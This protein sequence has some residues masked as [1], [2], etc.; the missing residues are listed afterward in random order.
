MPRRSLF[1]L[2]CVIALQRAAFAQDSA[3]V[4]WIRET[5]IPLR[6]VDAG[7]GFAD[8]APLKAVLANVRI[9]GLGESSHGTSEFQRVKHRLF[10]FLV[11]EMGYTVF[12][13]E[14]SYSDAQ[15]MNDYILH[16][17]GN[18]ADVLS[19]LGYVAWDME[20]F[21]AMV[22]W[23]RA[24]NRTVPEARK[25]RF[26]G[27][28]I[29]R[30]SVGR[31]KVLATVRRVLPT[32][33][34]TTD[35]LFRTLAEQERRWPSW[36][37]TV[38]A[39]ARAPLDALASK[40]EARRHAAPAEL[41]PAEWDE[42]IQLVDVMRQQAVLQHRD[43]YMAQ[44]LVYVIDHEAL[45]RK[46]VYWAH[47]VHVNT[48]SLSP[49]EP[50]ITSSK[51]ISAGAFLRKRYGDRYYA[52]GLYFNQGTYL[53]RLIFP[54]RDFDI[55][56]RPPAAEGTLEWFLAR[57]GLPRFFLDLRAPSGKPAV[58]AW[59]RTS[60]MAFAGVWASDYTEA[61]SQSLKVR[62]W[63]DGLLFVSESTPT[64]PTPNARNIVARKEGF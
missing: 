44:N 38:I 52:L 57:A 7:S 59:L 33:V 51:V 58:E 15:P 60:R 53:T 17:K 45:G 18:R 46:F 16:G 3:V 10:E 32:A 61:L 9:V 14:A 48:D 30:N 42:T 34:A 35:S 23:M 37:T 21:A 50:R 12:T 27:V 11:K 20:E 26:Y 29:Y 19:K 24:Y 36:D 43:Q 28:D 41:T 40:L 1:L 2:L 4:S 8:L 6:T 62:H 64:H 13:M 54:P 56:T 63:Y 49:S 39:A 22:D 47:D 55:K 5:A 31:E 25:I